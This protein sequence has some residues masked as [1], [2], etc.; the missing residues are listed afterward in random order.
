MVLFGL[1]ICITIMAAAWMA[2]EEFDSILARIGATF[3]FIVPTGVFVG[4]IWLMA[5]LIIGL[6]LPKD[7]VYQNYDLAA[8]NDSSS[9]SGAMF[10]GSGVIDGTMKYSYYRADGAAK[11]LET[12]NAS[13][14]RVFEDTDKAYVRK[15]VNCTS[16]W[17]WLTSCV[18]SPEVVEIHVPKST[19]RQGFVLDAK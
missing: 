14:I 18:M 10:L 16:S 17:E 7:I 12:V 1:A 2:A 13:D 15:S 6:L 5:A 11:Q 3:I 8:L 19:I 4:L 9:V